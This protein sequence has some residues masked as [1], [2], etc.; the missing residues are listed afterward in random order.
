MA[1]FRILL[2]YN[3]SPNDQKAI[4][5]TIDASG[6]GRAASTLKAAPS[7]S[8]TASLTSRMDRR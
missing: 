5:F 6:A 1:T 4:R 3:Y 7:S 8:S 2:P